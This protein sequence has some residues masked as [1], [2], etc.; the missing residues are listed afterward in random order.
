M[1]RYSTVW[2]QSQDF[3]ASSSF[4]RTFQVLEILH[5]SRTFQEAWE[6]CYMYCAVWQQSVVGCR[7]E[8]IDLLPVQEAAPAHLTGPTQHRLQLGHV[9]RRGV[10][11]HDTAGHLHSGCT[12]ASGLHRYSRAQGDSDTSNA[13]HHE[14]NNDRLTAFDPGQPG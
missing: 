11:I 13:V 14:M 9:H 2:Q 10:V 8:S 6:A 12:A 5:N 7:D 3:P 4:S 1:Y